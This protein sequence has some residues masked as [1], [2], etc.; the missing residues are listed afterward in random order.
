MAALPEK[1]RLAVV[2]VVG[3]GWSFAEVARLTGK[4]EATVRGLVA[5]GM[6]QLRRDLNVEESP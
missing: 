6:R 3:F 4:S 2:L 1:Q 5:R